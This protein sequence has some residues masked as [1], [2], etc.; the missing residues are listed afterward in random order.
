MVV[1]GTTGCQM[2][3][4]GPLLRDLLIG[5][6]FSRVLDVDDFALMAPLYPVNLTS[7]GGEAPVDGGD[8]AGQAGFGVLGRR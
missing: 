1:A 5:Q 7:L 4:G 8:G 3:F 2:T 6:V